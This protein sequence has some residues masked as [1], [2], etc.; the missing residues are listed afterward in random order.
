[1]FG[2]RLHPMR[3][4]TLLEAVLALAILSS[5]IVVCL[6]LRASAIENNQRLAGRAAAHRD[7]EAIFEMLTSKLLPSPEIDPKTLTRIWRGESSGVPYVLTAS[8]VVL[9][10]PVA[11]LAMNE[12]AGL[13]SQIIMWRYELTIRGRTSEFLW[14]Q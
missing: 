7:T 12:N 11:G 3:G 4:F 13:S 2:T 14:N 6:G 1:M 5:V 9:P 10:N 8:R